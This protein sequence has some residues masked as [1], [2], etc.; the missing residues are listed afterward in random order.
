MVSVYQ[1]TLKEEAH[2][3][4]GS[5]HCSV[6]IMMKECEVLIQKEKSSKTHPWL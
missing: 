2:K 3:N 6:L 4:H 1:Q 5:L